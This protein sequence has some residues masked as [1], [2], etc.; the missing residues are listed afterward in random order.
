MLIAHGD[1]VQ[2]G[3]TKLLNAANVT[4]SKGKPVQEYNIEFLYL[5]TN[6]RHLA[7]T[8]IQHQEQRV[9]NL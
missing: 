3:R 9:A 5:I 2:L 8:L 1:V 7:S 4:G 6:L